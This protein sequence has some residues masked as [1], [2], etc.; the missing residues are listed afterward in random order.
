MQMYVLRSRHIDEVDEIEKRDKIEI[1]LKIIS[2]I[3]NLILKLWI[4][5]MLIDMILNMINILDI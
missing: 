2:I 3:F 1:K 4:I 5:F